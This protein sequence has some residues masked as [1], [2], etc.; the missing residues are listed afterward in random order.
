MDYK[1]VVA[2]WVSLRG[3]YWLE[4]YHDEHGYSYRSD[5]GAGTL[6]HTIETDYAATT[7]LLTGQIVAANFP[8]KYK[9]EL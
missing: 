5:N 7:A 6:S 1:R 8:G 3:K 9:R 2:R 4:L